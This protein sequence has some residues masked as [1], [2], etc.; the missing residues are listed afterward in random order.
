MSPCILTKGHFTLD[1]SAA[2]ADKVDPSTNNLAFA[3]NPGEL[4]QGAA[5]EKLD[6]EPQTFAGFV[7][8][9]HSH[10]GCIQLSGV[11][12]VCVTLD[13]ARPLTAR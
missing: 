8:V 1:T 13:R 9:K 5:L 10:V 7:P 6:W 2:A 11:T 3:I 4:V 12:G